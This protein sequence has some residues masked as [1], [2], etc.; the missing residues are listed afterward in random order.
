MWTRNSNWNLDNALAVNATQNANQ[1]AQLM[2]EQARRA[3]KGE[4]GKGQGWPTTRSLICITGRAVNGF[5]LIQ[6]K[7]RERKRERGE[8]GAKGSSRRQFVERLNYKRK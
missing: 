2:P 1:F 5:G 4:G 3:S 8:E 6:K 7:G